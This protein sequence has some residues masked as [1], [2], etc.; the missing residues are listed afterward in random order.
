VLAPAGAAWQRD[1]SAVVDVLLADDPSTEAGRAALTAVRAAAGELTGVRVG[2]TAA[3]DADSVVA[4]YGNAWWVLLLVVV[5]TFALLAPA[6]RSVWLP[7]KAL[8]LN[9]LSIG[10]AYGM[11]VW[12]WQQGH[13]T[14]TLFGSP[15]V[16]TLTFWVP[17]AAFS[18]LFG[19]SMDY[20]VFIL[21][22][23]REGH[24]RG[25]S[26]DEAT[27]HGLSY[28]GRL[29]TSAA[30]ILFLAF[31]ALS[32]VPVVDV[33]IFATTLALGILLDATV[34]RGVLAPALVA[35]F[36]KVNWWWPPLLS[37]GR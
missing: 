23:I 16:G 17:V 5:V 8:L 24:E 18:F 30:L 12:I 35:A 34:V 31:V 6:L 9:V 32:T 33:K 19:L 7:V 26:T 3:G 1:G 21:T 25:M 15:A 13:L 22:R 29:V 27:V 4:V 36:G 20:E 37:R 10:A 11:T 14:E 28:T 2:G